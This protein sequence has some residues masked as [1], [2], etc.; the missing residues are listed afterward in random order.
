M[1]LVPPCRRASRDAK[2][3]RNHHGARELIDLLAGKAKG[4]VRACPVVA[5]DVLRRVYAPI[6]RLAVRDRNTEAFTTVRYALVLGALIALLAP[7]VGAEQIAGASYA[8]PVERYGHFALGR[9]HEYANLVA[10]TGAGREAVL[11]LPP[12][13]VFEDLAPRVV[14][15]S[16]D[17]QAELLVIVSARGSGSRLALVG[18]KGGRLEIV[19]QSASTGMSNRWLNPVGVADLDGDGVAEIAAV[20]TP[21]IGGVLRIYRRRGERLIE[22]ASLAGFS[23]H[24]YR[25][26][27]LG[28]SKPAMIAGRMQLL[29]PDAERAS[30][31]VIALK[32][33]ALVETARCPLAAPITSPVALRAC[34]ASLKTSRGAIPDRARVTQR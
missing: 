4:R 5:R 14:R 12:G 28:L 13:E 25:T 22:F 3:T 24:V 31:R 19:A 2:E 15:L 6:V 32:G 10:K 30:V 16:A 11:E 20:T 7:P 23:N 34:E 29:V 1:A 17:A 27:E 21:H 18:L 8:D 33:S 9:P 26:T